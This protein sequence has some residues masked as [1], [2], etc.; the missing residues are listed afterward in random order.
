MS[1]KDKIVIFRIGSLGDTAL[2]I[3][4]FHLI[5]KTF[6]KACITLL[7]NIPSSS[8]AAPV[9]DVLGQ[10]SGFVDNVLDY[11][12]GLSNPLEAIRLI[13]KLRKLQP[14]TLVY[15]MPERT[16]HQIKRDIIFFRISGFRN[17]LCLPK[18]DD[19]RLTRYDGET[20][21]EESEAQR[22]V[23]CISSLGTIDLSDDKLWDLKLSAEEIK[24]GMKLT[25]KIPKPFL[26]IHTGCKAQSKD[27]GFKNWSELIKKFQI[28]TKAM[29]LMIVGSKED[30]Q[31]ANTLSEVW[32]KG[33]FNF[34]GI[35]SPRETA[36]ALHFA[37]LFC[38]HDSGPMHIARCVGVQTLGIFG[39]TNKPKKWHPLG[40]NVT[41][42]HEMK[43]ID[44][45]SVDNVLQQLKVI[46]KRSLK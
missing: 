26:C 22:L 40:N 28:E 5:R 23:R 30:Y 1:S 8:K 24:K 25:T 33:A 27:W 16:R 10:D 13:I 38:G 42:I 31:R 29:G 39:D 44:K 4:C 21:I 20:G 11:T 17:I 37:N 2:A 41:I 36:A 12:S 45:I 34:C 9:I 18:N 15:L 35:T 6:P 14:S 3:P 46:W 43:G 7:T 32:G 19:Q